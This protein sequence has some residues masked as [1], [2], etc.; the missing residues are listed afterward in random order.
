[1]TINR[2]SVLVSVSGVGFGLVNT[3]L[4]VVSGGFGM[5]QDVSGSAVNDHGCLCDA[6]E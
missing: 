6:D 3:T 1:M 5:F 2:L 4:V